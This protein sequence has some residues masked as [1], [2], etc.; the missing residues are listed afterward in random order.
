M[1]KVVVM[2]VGLVAAFSVGLYGAAFWSSYQTE[3]SDEEIVIGR[4]GAVPGSHTM[5]AVNLYTGDEK[6]VIR[7]FFGQSWR[8]DY[9]G[10]CQCI[11]R[12]YKHDSYNVSLQSDGLVHYSTGETVSRTVSYAWVHLLFEEGMAIRDKIK[13]R[14]A[15]ILSL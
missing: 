14:H 7:P 1:K 10:K 8:I 13:D 2:L 11:T 5:Y 6:I 12:V 3:I 4:I 9:E 15:D